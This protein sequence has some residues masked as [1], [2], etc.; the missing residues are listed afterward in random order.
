M[1]RVAMG[2]QPLTFISYSRKDKD[3]ALELAN[4]L[5]AS[6]FSIWFDQLDIPTG[7][8]WDDEIQK[9]LEQ[10][11]IFMVILTPSST[12]SNN[13]KDEVGYAI[14][15]EKRILP[16]LLENAK[17]PFRLRRFQYVDFTNISHD[18]GIDRATQLLRKLVN[19]L[20]VSTQAVSSVAQNPETQTRAGHVAAKPK[21]DSNQLAHQRAEAMRVNRE[22]E[23]LRHQAQNIPPAQTTVNKPTERSIR[24]QPSSKLMPIM[25]GVT[26]ILFLCLGGIWVAWPYIFP[27]TPT[28]TLPAPIT[29]KPVDVT[30]PT[31]I[32]PEQP[33]ETIPTT[34][35][36][37]SIP[38][39][40]VDFVY[41]YYEN[42]NNRNYDLTWSLLSDQFRAKF[43]LDGKESYM[44]TWN[45]VSSV[46]IY[47][48]DYTKIS[49]TSA[50]VIV[51]TNIQSKPLNYYLI[52]DGSRNTWLFD[53]M[54]ESFNVSCSKA[55]KTLSV[56]NSALVATASETLLLRD[57]P[58]DGNKVE[59]LSPGTLVTVIGG[60]ECKYYRAQSVFFW[61]WKVQ[62][63]TGKEGWIVEG[64][65][66]KDAVFIQPVQ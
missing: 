8:R 64:S 27:S 62:S 21:D 6:G 66:S 41:F 36:P 15:S 52:W 4:E 26:L 37:Q 5:R 30:P 7:A 29:E 33:S 12:A 24:Q 3:F 45:K 28:D 34:P 65:D 39:Q 2:K 43:N 16:I 46:T 56:G 61:W 1:G 13:V 23:Q 58:T 11:E 47:S 40:P 14:D 55:P 60:P 20:V 63:P 53:P 44:D 18:E 10:C 59:E 49:D 17:A 31:R 25:I 51:N 35:A 38:S 9:A 54:P 57:A 50:I 48:A 42:I 19:E 22:R 32:T